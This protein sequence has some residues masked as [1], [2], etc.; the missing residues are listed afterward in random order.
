M[1]SIYAIFI[2]LPIFIISAQC[3]QNAID[4]YNKG[5]TLA[6]QGKY[7]EANQAYDQAI[8][9]KPNY[10]N[11][12]YNKGVAL[13]ALGRINESDAAFAEA[14]NLSNL[15]FGFVVSGPSPFTGGNFSVR[16]QP[17][18]YP[19]FYPGYMGYY[20]D[21]F[22]PYGY[23]YPFCDYSGY[24]TLPSLPPVESNKVVRPDF[25]DKGDHPHNHDD[26]GKPDGHHKDGKP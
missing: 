25:H 18:S 7:I 2:L 15:F 13:K 17:S 3:Q 20:P 10:E 6:G 21:Y 8:Q 11:A 9:L 24:F 4:W 26:C 16:T 23:Y 22:Y 14:R 19:E 5:D 1:K 12:W